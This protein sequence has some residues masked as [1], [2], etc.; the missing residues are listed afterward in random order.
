MNKNIHPQNYNFF[1]LVYNA[2]YFF[3]SY[4]LTPNYLKRDFIVIYQS[5]NYKLYASKKE[6]GRLAKYGLLFFGKDFNAYKKKVRKII[7]E[8]K[9]VFR[10]GRIKNFSNIS[11]Q[12]LREDFL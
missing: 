10:S 12:N 3:I 1:W 11:D 5:G 9:A 4:F 2:T 8:A 6:T 7:K